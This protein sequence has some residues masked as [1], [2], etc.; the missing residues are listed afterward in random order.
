MMPAPSAA[1][2]TVMTDSTLAVAAPSPVRLAPAILLAL[3]AVYVIWGSTYLAIRL[4]LVDIP[5]FLQIGSR[6]LVAAL[7]LF[8]WL[9]SRGV[10]WPDRRGWRAAGIVGVLLIGG[11]TGGVAVAQQWV[12][13]GLAAVVVA[14]VPLWAALFNGCW[15]QWPRRAEWAGIG[16]G[17]LGVALLALEKDF[18]AE[19]RGAVVL[20]AAAALWAYGSML[21]R[22]LKLPPGASG[23]AAEMFAGGAV[24]VIAGL[25]CGERLR[26]PLQPSTPWLWGYLVVFGS[27]VGFSAYMYLVGRVR[28]ALA[29]SYAYVNPVI[30]VLLGV[31][32]GGESVSA[33]GY[34]AMALV[35]AAV[36]LI[37]RAGERARD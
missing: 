33:S 12:G 26:W 31:G 1:S 25:L 27:I 2:A 36:V 5:P 9:R 7:L 34:V 21:S 11:G 29:T 24:L 35:L 17:F 16:I 14:T 8:A 37:T 28:P 18:R 4:V 15:G 10:P 20:L 23:F 13:S 32:V 30:A 6:S 3:A 22:R 19:P